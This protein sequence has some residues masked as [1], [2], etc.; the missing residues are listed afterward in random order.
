[1]EHGINSAYSPLLVHS[2]RQDKNKAREAN[3]RERQRQGEAPSK[4]KIRKR[5]YTAA[6]LNDSPGVLIASTHSGLMT[7]EIFF[8]SVNHFLESRLNDA[9]PAILLLD[10]HGSRWSVQYRNYDD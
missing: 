2:H 4:L 5:C 1:M 7:Q 3:K 6:H 10:G 9:G 8:H